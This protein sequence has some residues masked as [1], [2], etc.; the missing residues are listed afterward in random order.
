[1]AFNIVGH[2]SCVPG[3]AYYTFGFVGLVFTLFH[4]VHAAYNLRQQVGV[5][6]S[7]Q[8]DGAAKMGSSLLVTVLML[9]SLDST[10]VTATLNV[11]TPSTN[12]CGH[13][14]VARLSEAGAGWW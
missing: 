6:A 13:S 12:A 14:A 7:W 5:R 8:N 9:V 1:M 10:T 3:A 4:L 11:V 2:A